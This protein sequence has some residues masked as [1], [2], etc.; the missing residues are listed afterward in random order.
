MSPITGLRT[1]KLEPE[2]DSG[3]ASGSS[4]VIDRLTS[5]G[6]VEVPVEFTVDKN[7]FSDSVAWAA[8]IL[9]ARPATPILTGIKIEALDDNNI[10]ISAFDYEVSAREMISGDVE[11]PGE[12]LVAGKLL[13]EIVKSLP[14]ATV[15]CRTNGGRLEIRS[16]NANYSLQEMPLS[17]YP[18][19]PMVP[20]TIGSIPADA[21]KNS[22][23]K[24]AFAA[25]NREEA[26]PVFT[27]VKFAFNDDN[28]NMVATDKIRLA[29][30][31]LPWDGASVESSTPVVVKA[32]VAQDVARSLSP[33]SNQV[34]I[35]LAIDAGLN[36]ISFTSG[37]RVTTSQLIDGGYPNVMG[38]FAD[39]YP[40]KVALGKDALMNALRRVALV[41]DREVILKFREGEVELVAGAGEEANAVEIIP[42]ELDGED[43]TI[44]LRPNYLIDGLSVL[45]EGFA[46]LNMTHKIKPV[47]MRGQESIETSGSEQFRYLFVPIRTTD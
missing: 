46:S 2:P 28:V 18:K 15:S 43:I 36:V 38:L 1:T 5:N 32:R 14:G 40:I 11:V 31:D 17:D 13:A 23:Q 25:A 42:C 22:I 34:E 35:G 7:S 45:E 3:T 4:L 6:K 27:G 20:E 19:L 41:S 9:P 33:E 30:F 21:F 29:K 12:V 24:V 16:G 47:E 39:S 10:K 37:N 8:R 26:N 44:A